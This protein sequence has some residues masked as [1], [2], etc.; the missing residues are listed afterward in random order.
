MASTTFATGN[1]LTRKAWATGLWA[2]V[3]SQT[4]LS[5]FVG[6]NSNSIIHEKSELKK[7]RG[8]KITVGIRVKMS[9]DGVAGS[10]TL[11]GNEEALTVHSDAIVIDQL[12]HAT[13][14]E[15]RTDQQRVGFDIREEGRLALADWFA[16]RIDTIGFNHLCGNTAIES[17]AEP[18]LRNGHNTIVAVDSDHIVRPGSHTTDTLVAADTSATFDLALL[19]KAVKEAKLLDPNPLRTVSVGGFNDVYVVV[20]HPEQVEQL[21]NDTSTG[22]WYDTM[23]NALTGGRVDDNPLI[24]GSLGVAEGC[25]FV[26]NSRITQ[27]VT[28]AG[29][30]NQ[31]NTRRAVLLGAQAAICAYG[32]DNGSGRYQ[33][34]EETFDFGQQLG[35][36]AS[37]I[38]GF[39]TARFNSQNYGSIVIPTY[40]AT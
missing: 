33:W 6:S 25:L 24:T 7:G 1:A 29:T 35:I 11:E 13:R 28:V 27:G 14:S 20:L 22:G 21:R 10:A 15:Q 26:E 4:T 16:D 9:G 31:A 23:K 38:S 18:E 3:T 8:D 5:G 40:S 19:R 2:E 34:N 39:K 32:Q 37:C 30:A 36:A 17:L 12:R